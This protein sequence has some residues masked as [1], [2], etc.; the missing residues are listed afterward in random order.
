[1]HSSQMFE[2]LPFPFLHSVSV[3]CLGMGQHFD[4][5]TRLSGC[6]HRAS[7]PQ[8]QIP[9]RP[10]HDNTQLICRPFEFIPDGRI[11]H[12]PLC[13]REAKWIF[14]QLGLPPSCRNALV[15]VDVLSR[16]L[17][18][19]MG[20]SITG[21]G[22]ANISRGGSYTSRSYRGQLFSTYLETCHERIQKIAQFARQWIPSS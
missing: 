12:L 19:V 6:C 14:K 13:Q 7:P 2:I 11:K 5:A 21:V 15:E 3:V 22:I 8:A 20:D 9:A 1:M 17:V 16:A 18:I 10:S 4:S